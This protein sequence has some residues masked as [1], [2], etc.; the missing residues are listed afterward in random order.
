MS[1]DEWEITAERETYLA[2]LLMRQWRTLRAER[3]D[4]RLFYGVAGLVCDDHGHIPADRLLAA[5]HDDD[6]VGRALAL[7]SVVRYLMGDGGEWRP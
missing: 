4:E 2:R 7:L 5:V 1:L 6:V 3:P